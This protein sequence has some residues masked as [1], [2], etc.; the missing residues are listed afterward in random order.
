[1]GYRY[2]IVLPLLAA[3]AC[4][5]KPPAEEPKG[6]PEACPAACA[7]LRELG[8]EEAEPTP[9]GAT[10]EDVCKSIETSNLVSVGPACVARAETCESV[11]ECLAGGE[12]SAP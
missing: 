7:K 10:C 3:V 1:M 11:G 9:N 6:E 8:C 4:F 2:L 12:F 5:Q